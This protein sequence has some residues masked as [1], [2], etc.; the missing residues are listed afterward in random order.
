ML[1]IVHQCFPMTLLCKII[2]FK[3]ILQTT[4]K[5]L[6]FL[7]VLNYFLSGKNAT[8][9]NPGTRSSVARQRRAQSSG[10]SDSDAS[11]KGM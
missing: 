4:N 5:F 7:F 11:D 2:V 1:L 9:R 6:L 8:S 3:P 10:S